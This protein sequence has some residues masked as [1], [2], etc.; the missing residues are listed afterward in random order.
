MVKLRMKKTLVIML[1]V[2]FLMASTAASVSACYDKAKC[3]CKDNYDSKAKYDCKEKCDS[4]MKY[5][6]KEKYDSKNKYDFKDKYGFKDYKYDD[7]F[8]FDFLWIIFG[9]I[10]DDGKCFSEFG[11]CSY[12]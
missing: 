1:A 3:D 2:F 5:D 12:K 10:F 11:K 6:C 4:K 8:S 9:N 7:C